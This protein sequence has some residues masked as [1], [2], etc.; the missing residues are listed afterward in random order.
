MASGLAKRAGRTFR[1]PWP[2][3][4]GK[5]KSDYSPSDILLRTRGQSADRLAIDVEQHA[6]AGVEVEGYSRSMLR[7]HEVSIL[8]LLLPW[9]RAIDQNCSTLRHRQKSTISFKELYSNN[10]LYSP[11]PLLSRANSYFALYKAL[12]KPLVNCNILSKVVRGKL[13]IY[14]CQEMLSIYP[15]FSLK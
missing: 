8:F 11:A 12:N 4:W 9:W 10:P 5:F 7:T 2:I 13:K 6:R 3:S 1:K 15:N 14:S